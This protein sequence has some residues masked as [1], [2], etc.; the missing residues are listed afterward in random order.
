MKPIKTLT[1]RSTYN[2]LPDNWE[3]IT[4]EL[5]EK[6]YL[7]DYQE[8]TYAFADFVDN[9]II[10]IHEIVKKYLYREFLKSGTPEG[11]G[12]FYATLVYDVKVKILDMSKVEEYINYRFREGYLLF[13]Q[14]YDYNLLN[15]HIVDYFTKWHRDRDI[16]EFNLWGGKNVI[17]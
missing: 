5:D 14:Y 10:E 4:K 6:N 16:D 1:V 3:D 15:G 12:K 11:S 13:S 2:K 9:D 7:L 8:L 17:I